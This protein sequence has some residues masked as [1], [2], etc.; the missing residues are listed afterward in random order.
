MQS[1]L[2]RFLSTK[3]VSHLSAPSV[4]IN[5]SV[6]N[7]Q[8]ELSTFSPPSKEWEP[9]LE[10]QRGSCVNDNPAPCEVG[11]LKAQVFILRKMAIESLLKIWIDYIL[12]F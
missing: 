9:L 12:L 5:N 8:N 11:S 6:F 2:F 4:H 1:T 3:Y 10:L 7:I